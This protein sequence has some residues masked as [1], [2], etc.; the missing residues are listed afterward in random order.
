VLAHYADGGWGTVVREQRETG[1]YSDELAWALADLV[2]KQHFDPEIEWVTCVPS[3]RAPSLVRD[4][5][6]RVAG[7]LRLPFVPVL[8]KARE[9]GPQKEMSNSAQ[10]SANVG[11]AFSVT[12]EVPSGAV[13]L[14]D[15]IVDSGWTLTV[16]ADV[17]RNNGSGPVHPALLAQARS[18]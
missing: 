16:V 14:I 7:R 13:L 9:T 3:L 18:D 5:A 17:L 12:G 10:Q 2:A 8:Q 1:A 11:G 6:E 4:L 15:D